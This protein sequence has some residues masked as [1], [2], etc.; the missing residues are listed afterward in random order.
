MAAMNPTIVSNSGHAYARQFLPQIPSPL[1]E[2]EG[3]IPN[4][5]FSMP[6]PQLQPPPAHLGGSSHNLT[7]PP[8]S[9]ASTQPQLN[10]GP[11][12][13][14]AAAATFAQASPHQVFYR[15]KKTFYCRFL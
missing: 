13:A 15:T 7:P 3:K 11:P 5:S 12:S 14:V 4:C 6:L 2:L 8:T 10:S 9:S 1:A